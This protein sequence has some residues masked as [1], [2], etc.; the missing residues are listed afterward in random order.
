MNN[1][2]QMCN[3]ASP[4]RTGTI[5]AIGAAAGYLALYFWHTLCGNAV[6][7]RGVFHSKTAR[8]S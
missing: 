2:P 7:C 4:P 3:K 5:R 6:H 8:G 1:E